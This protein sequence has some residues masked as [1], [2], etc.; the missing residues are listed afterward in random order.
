MPDAITQLSE[1]LIRA[2]GHSL[3]QAALISGI[4]WLLLRTL[5]AKYAERRYAI[6]SG[7]IGRHRRCRVGHVVRVETGADRIQQRCDT[8]QSANGAGRSHFRRSSGTASSSPAEPH[9]E[10]AELAEHTGRIRLPSAADATSSINRSGPIVVRWLAVIWLCGAVVMLLRGLAG[11]VIARRWLVESAA[12]AESGLQEL[13]EIVK[14]LSGRLKL[15]RIVQIV[16]SDRIDTP[17]VVGVIWPVIMVPVSMLTGVP[18]DQWRIMIA[19]EL[20]HIRRWDPLVSLIQMVVE[21]LLF[22]NPFVWWLNRIIRAE[23]EACCDAVA[24]RICGQPMSVAK[25]LVDVAAS[26]HRPVIS[27]AMAFAE[28][29]REGELSDRVLRLVQ[30]DRPPRSKI[31]WLSVSV[32]MVALAATFILLQRGTDIAVQTAANWMSPKERVEKLVQLEAERNGNFVPAVA[33]SADGS[34]A[35]DDPNAGKIAVHVIVKTDDGSKITPKLTLHYQS[36][37]GNNSS[38]GPSTVS[39]QKN[40]STEDSLFSSVPITDRSFPS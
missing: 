34:S 3:W 15:R 28:P 27:S 24:A 7:R 19:H 31:S 9:A 17:A 1:T 36:R 16:L 2:L 10:V 14:E 38:A 6:A 40:W 30:P 37:A 26:I 18:A 21:S 33:A 35:S 12:V 5:P 20:A 8:K 11:F 32:V 39:M 23:R 22:F 4:V 13:T 29:S 25:T